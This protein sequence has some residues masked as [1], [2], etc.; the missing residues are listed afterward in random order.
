MIDRDPLSGAKGNIT[1]GYK[2]LMNGFFTFGRFIF[3]PRFFGIYKL[4]VPPN[5]PTIP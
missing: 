4:A 1:V 5:V 3:H 2:D